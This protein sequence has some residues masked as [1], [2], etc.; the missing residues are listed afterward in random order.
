MQSVAQS[1]SQPLPERLDMP[2]PMLHSNMHHPKI[3]ISNYI[4]IG[5]R[6]SIFPQMPLFRNSAPT[7]PLTLVP[8]GSPDLLTNTHALSSNL[9]TLPSGL[10]YFF[11]VRTTTACRISPRLTLFPAL[12]EEPAC[13]AASAPKLRCF[14]TTTTMR[15]PMTAISGALDTGLATKQG[16]LAR[17]TLR[18]VIKYAVALL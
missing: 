6:L 13:F 15:S 14:W 7:I 1:N 10:W 18:S 16:R 17:V 5:A 9:T 3:N 4:C 11:A 12:T 8:I 2:A